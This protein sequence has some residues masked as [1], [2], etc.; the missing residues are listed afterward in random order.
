MFALLL[1]GVSWWT[2]ESSS[3]S[4]L[5]EAAPAVSFDIETAMPAG[6]V[7][8]MTLQSRITLPYGPDLYQRDPPQDDQDQ[9]YQGYGF[10][11]SGA[12]QIVYDPNHHYLY[13]MSDQGYVTIADYQD[14][15][16]PQLTRLS[17][18]T[19]HPKVGGIE[20]CPSQGVFLVS[21]EKLGQVAIYSL[22]NRTQPEEKPRLIK[23]LDAGPECKTVLPNHDC[24]II[25]VGNT[26]EG[27]ALT[28]GQITIL[29]DPLTST[30]TKKTISLDFDSWNDDYL[31]RRGLNMPLTKAAMEYWDD[32]SHLADEIDWALERANYRS[33]IFLE[34][35]NL[36]WNDPSETELLVN[37]QENNG[38][39]R[40]NMTDLTPVAVAG[41]GLRDHSR[42]PVDLVADGGCDLKTYPGVFAMLNPDGFS[43]IRYGSK[44]YIVT[45][46]EG[47]NKKYADWSEEWSSNELFT[48]STCY[49]TREYDTT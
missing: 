8:G 9:P 37:L 3:R 15:S 34:P 24:S 32:H 42:I 4:F 10:G 19:P 30:P 21:L 27:E 39:L 22:V 46:N 6:N 20:I 35:E 49:T 2:D 1:L 40:I 26:N 31:L 13:T 25:V 33:A 29:F 47:G 28:Q 12:E 16:H 44:T 45:A 17:I 11:M 43:A 23:T 41:Y 18:P 14:P 48:V 36:A 38:L 7:L 5:V